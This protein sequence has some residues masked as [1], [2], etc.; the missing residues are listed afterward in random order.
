VVSNGFDPST[1]TIQR[2]ND[3]TWNFQAGGHNV[4]F[5]DGVNNS[6]DKNAGSNHQRSFSTA[7]DYRYRCTN[8]SADFTSGMAGRVVV[9][10]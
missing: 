1:V 9:Q 10:Q 8:H 2:N 7:G 6:G 5:E 4:T 3:V